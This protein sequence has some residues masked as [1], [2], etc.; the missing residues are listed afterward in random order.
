MTVVF[1]T[2]NQHWYGLQ[3][4]VVP[5]SNY[6][7][8][9]VCIRFYRSSL[10]LNVIFCLIFFLILFSSQELILK[11]NIME[12]TVINK[13]PYFLCSMYKTQHANRVYAAFYCLNFSCSLNLLLL[14]LSASHQFTLANPLQSPEHKHICGVFQHALVLDLPLLQL[15]TKINPSKSWAFQTARK[16]T[17]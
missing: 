5:R 10:W 11:L 16:T 3:S 14:P 8:H 6:L 4:K 2:V 1:V 15:Q 7:G 13:Q 12:N 17:N 9:A